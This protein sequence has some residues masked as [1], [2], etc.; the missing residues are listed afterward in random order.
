[1][2]VYETERDRIVLRVVY[3]GAGLVGKTSN[4]EQLALAFH[5]QFV[6]DPPDDD[7]AAGPAPPGRTRL[8]DWFVFDGGKLDGHGL[9]IQVIAVPGHKRFEARRAR[10]LR[11]ADAIVFVC[12][13]DPAALASTREALDSQRE[14]LGALADEI[15]L[16]VQ[17]NKQDLANALQPQE[18]GTSLG[19]P[20]EVPVLAAQ[21]SQGIG[22]RE[23]V[24]QAVRTAVRRIKRQITHGGL[25]SLA[26][27]AENAATLRADMARISPY[28]A[29]ED[30]PKATASR[31]RRRPA[32]RLT[33]VNEPK[34]VQ[35]RAAKASKFG[36]RTPVGESRE[37]P[38]PAAKPEPTR[39]P[40]DATKPALFFDDEPTPRP[41]PP[42]QPLPPTPPSERVTLPGAASHP[43]T[44][45]SEGEL[46]PA[47]LHALVEIAT[48]PLVPA[49]AKPA[50]PKHPA[51]PNNLS[52]GPASKPPATPAS[53]LS[54]KP[55]APPRPTDKLSLGP[56]SRAPRRI[57]SAP[58]IPM[59]PATA[60]PSGKPARRPRTRPQLVI[61]APAPLPPTP[62]V[63]PPLSRA[64]ATPKSTEPASAKPDTTAQPMATFKPPTRPAAAPAT[65]ASATTRIPVA[66]ASPASTP[67][68][69][70]TTTVPGSATAARSP[71]ASTPGSGS[72]A[73]TPAAA[74]PASVTAARPPVTATTPASAPAR[75]TSATSASAPARSTSGAPA[76][77]STPVASGTPA[78]ATA[79]RPPVGPASDPAELE[80]LPPLPRP[81]VPTG[82]V[83]PIPRGRDILR[84][85]IDSPLERLP[86]PPRQSTHPPLLLAAGA[87]RLYSSDALRYPDIEAAHAALLE[88]VRHTRPC[89]PLLAR[90]L[91]L[92]VQAEGDGARLWHIVP[93]L[94]G[95]REHLALR[96]PQARP[97]LLAGLASAVIA[98]L[99]LWLRHGV[100]L[101]LDLG[102]FAV[103]A[104]R[105]V[106][107]GDRLGTQPRDLGV[108][109]LGLC[110]RLSG[111]VAALAAFT[112]AL[113]Q[114]LAELTTE[115]RARLEL[116][117]ALL[118]A[119]TRYQD[120]HAARN[121]LLAAL[122]APT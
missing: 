109:L 114:E 57:P 78:S 1:M 80:S 108:A 113:E 94:D 61:P 88:R 58:E 85:L 50:P 75:G 3:D 16:I 112:A 115:E 6:A 59:T 116:E 70:A 51:A 12:D 100:A 72:G 65:T 4:L 48:A 33:I 31:T 35:M 101:D 47:T 45:P 17:T 98:A 66:S 92:V 49:A 83:W 19:L 82:H 60:D 34:V 15:P 28:A 110:E 27:T 68:R 62:L 52:P 5:G 119:E 81:N 9:R 87:W 22:V 42:A 84:E 89:A 95:I 103:E 2:A 14:Y 118:R 122:R 44:L 25:A 54:A 46:A 29:P 37:F 8:F 64:R 71:A 63:L 73:R 121:R 55:A 26:G 18:I 120:A 97:R 10:L 30:A 39:E 13:S 107:L 90:D 99:R 38:P 102:S 117:A 74:T 111:D 76:S 24:V 86:A 56:A 11:S 69:T 104:G 36:T 79:T 67:A 20:L 105:V 41:S 96:P 77:A 40:S 32:Q 23:T 53:D 43:P 21:T 91:V 106:H 7:T 93:R